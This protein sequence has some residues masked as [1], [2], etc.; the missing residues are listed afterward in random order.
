MKATPNRSNGK[1]T[2]KDSAAVSWARARTRKDRSPNGSRDEQTKAIERS[3]AA[4][5]W[6]KA[7]SLLHDELI[8]APAD[9]WLWTTLGATYY[10][11]K[12]YE[13]ALKC[14]EH[15]VQ[16]APSCPLALWDYA[17]SLYMTGHEDAALA[18]W[19]VIRNMDLDTLAHGDHGEGMPWALQLVN[20][21]QY[22]I[23]R[24]YQRVGEMRLARECYEKYLHNRKHGVGSIYEV[25]AVQGHL[26]ELPG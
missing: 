21:A 16:L 19:T 3:L 7:R 18:V 11:E 26:A 17:G 15:A 25:A 10:E 6:D 2:K 1:T 22:R 8:F 9:H 4:K 13:K 14:C 12:E 5:K 23:G 20:D 24:N